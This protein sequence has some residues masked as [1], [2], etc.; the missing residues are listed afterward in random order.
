MEYR[1]W[2]MYNHMAGQVV[3]FSLIFHTPWDLSTKDET[4]YC[5][6]DMKLSKNDNPIIKLIC[7]TW[8]YL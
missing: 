2:S 6:D 5:K 1:L 8:L 7:L 3:S 4:V